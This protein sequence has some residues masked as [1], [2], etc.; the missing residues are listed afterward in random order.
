M[1]AAE[2]RMRS[3]AQHKIWKVGRW[4]SI[5]GEKFRTFCHI[6]SCIQYTDRKTEWQ[7][8][9]LRAEIG[10]SMLIRVSIGIEDVED[11][12]SDLGQA[13]DVIWVGA[14]S[15]GLNHPK[16]SIRN[17]GGLDLE[18]VAIDLADRDLQLRRGSARCLC[19]IPGC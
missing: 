10:L 7:P 2:P 4:R 5:F 15:G 17:W 19:G 1:D 8:A 3:S 12:I 16:A 6:L 9:T 14:G 18:I 13:L 11:L